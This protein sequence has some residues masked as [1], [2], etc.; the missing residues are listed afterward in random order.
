[1]YLIKN[2]DVGKRTIFQVSLCM[3]LPFLTSPR[4]LK[5]QDNIWG[6][7]EISSGWKNEYW[8]PNLN[9]RSFSVIF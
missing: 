8:V 7:L 5:V 3:D 9:K 2:V 6:M 4:K 1:M